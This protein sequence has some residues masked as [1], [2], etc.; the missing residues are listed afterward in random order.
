MNQVK[1]EMEYKEMRECTF[2]PKINSRAKR[3][4]SEVKIQSV[5]GFDSYCKKVE[6][7]HWIKNEK[8]EREEKLFQMEKA[9]KNRKSTN[10]V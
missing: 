2:K 8:K 9:Y 7:I 5:K 1:M 4:N 6:K 3:S 10:P